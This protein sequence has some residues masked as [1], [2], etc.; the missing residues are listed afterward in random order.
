MA[1]LYQA[2]NELRCYLKFAKTMFC[3]FILQA[4]NSTPHPNS[5]PKLW[6][7][8]NVS[9]TFYV[10]CGQSEIYVVTLQGFHFYCITSTF[11]WNPDAIRLITLCGSS[12]MNFRCIRWR[13]LKLLLP[14]HNCLVTNQFCFFVETPCVWR[15]CIRSCV[16]PASHGM[17]SMQRKEKGKVAVIIYRNSKHKK[18]AIHICRRILA[19]FE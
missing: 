2:G 5:V 9:S 14:R 17:P 19:R 11:S 15:L 18:T 10:N 4:V 3:G 6:G 12:R 16:F 1:S 7:Q 13:A 8:K